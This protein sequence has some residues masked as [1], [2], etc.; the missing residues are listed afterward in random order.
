MIPVLFLKTDYTSLPIITFA[1][2]YFKSWD[3]IYQITHC[4]F[5]TG[6]EDGNRNYSILCNFQIP[7]KKITFV[8]RKLKKSVTNET[9]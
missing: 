3:K 7:F 9:F 1:S 6:T 5:V 2:V 8:I 4:N